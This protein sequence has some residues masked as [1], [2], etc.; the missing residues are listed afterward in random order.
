MRMKAR[1]GKKV[2]DTCME[3][4]Q[5]SF[6]KQDTAKVKVGGVRTGLRYISVT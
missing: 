3:T 2:F 6:Q 4:Q 5:S 1:A